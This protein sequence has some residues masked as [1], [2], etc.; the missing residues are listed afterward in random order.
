MQT[1]MCIENY[2]F[3]LAKLFKESHEN[4]TEAFLAPGHGLK[5][6]LFPSEINSDLI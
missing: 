6:N 5:L 4:L 2:L 1:R 3:G